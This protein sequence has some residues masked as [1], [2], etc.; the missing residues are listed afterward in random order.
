MKT[1]IKRLPAPSS[2][3]AKEKKRVQ[4]LL[5]MWREAHDLMRAFAKQTPKVREEFFEKL[6][7]SAADNDNEQEDQQQDAEEDE[8]ED[9]QGQEQENEQEDQQDDQQESDSDDEG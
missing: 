9:E 7:Q 3:S 8:L 4:N 5:E 1:K 2:W 6:R